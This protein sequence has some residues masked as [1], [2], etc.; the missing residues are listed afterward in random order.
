MRFT[1]APRQPE[2]LTPQ[3]IPLTGQVQ[4]LANEVG[5]GNSRR[6]GR[7]RKTG[8]TLGMRQNAG[9]W[10]R[11]KYHIRLYSQQ[12]RLNLDIVFE[13]DHLVLIR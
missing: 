8:M 12:A 3:T 4:H 13:Q 9:K 11:V 1:I 6:C 7:L 2:R 10:I 5:I